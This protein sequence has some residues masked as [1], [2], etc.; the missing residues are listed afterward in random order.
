MSPGDSA[1]GDDLDPRVD[2]ANHYYI[3]KYP[4]SAEVFG[5]GKNFMD[6]FDADQYSSER[7]EHLYYPFAS[8][9]EWEFA[10]YLL[11][12]NLSMAAIDKLLKL[13]LV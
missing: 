4:G 13:E 1:L 6:H 12:S 5:P 11:Q 3:N 10:S 9:D 8:R 7:K 2:T